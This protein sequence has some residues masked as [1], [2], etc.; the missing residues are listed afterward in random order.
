MLGQWPSQIS[1]GE[2]RR[3]EDE[4]KEEAQPNG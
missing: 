1:I 3:K 2:E 4:N